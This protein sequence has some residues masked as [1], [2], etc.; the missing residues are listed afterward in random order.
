MG[1]TRHRDNCTKRSAPLGGDQSGKGQPEAVKDNPLRAAS[2]TTSKSIA[3]SIAATPA[4]NAISARVFGLDRMTRAAASR[5]P[6]TPTPGAARSVWTGLSL[7]A[8][9]EYTAGFAAS[10]SI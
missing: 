2:T 10:L 9:R 5:S 1:P 7:A 6:R 8:K 3:H 4:G